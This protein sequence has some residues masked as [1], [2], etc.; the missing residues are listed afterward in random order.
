MA[1]TGK[2]VD[3]WK[4]KY[5]ILMKALL[6]HLKRD[7]KYFN[8]CSVELQ[9]SGTISE[10]FLIFSKKLTLV[11]IFHNT[12]TLSPTIP[13]R[14]GSTQT[15]R[16]KNTTQS[17]RLS[18]ILFFPLVQYFWLVRAKLQLIGVHRE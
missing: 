18:C 2:L 7:R 9:V 16:V 14:T 4:C 1:Q 11:L 3:G 15:S 8:A 6:S 17:S 12:Q 10:I 5:E 13:L